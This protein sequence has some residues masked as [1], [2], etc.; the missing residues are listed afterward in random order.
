MTLAEIGE[1]LPAHKVAGIRQAIEAAGATLLYPLVFRGGF[2]KSGILS[3]QSPLCLAKFYRDRFSE[4]K[5]GVVG[6]GPYG[7]VK[8]AASVVQCSERLGPGR[9]DRDDL[10][11]TA[12]LEDLPDRIRQGAERELRV[13]LAEGLGD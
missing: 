10:V 2:Y 3:K 4:G 13:L 5:G 7:D 12:Y 6:R 11:E 1:K 8:P 9:V